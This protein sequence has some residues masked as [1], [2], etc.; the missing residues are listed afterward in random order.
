MELGERAL[1][2]DLIARHEIVEGCAAWVRAEIAEAARVSAA[3][4]FAPEAKVGMAAVE[5]S[6]LA[7]LD[8]AVAHAARWREDD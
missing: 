6:L 3:S 2:A 7:H 5:Q 4:H 1:L 8:E